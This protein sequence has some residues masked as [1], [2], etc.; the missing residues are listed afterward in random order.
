MGQ[1]KIPLVEECIYHICTKT[2]ADYVIF[3]AKKDYNR[4]L[5]TL[6]YYMHENIPCKFSAFL[7]LFENTKEEKL[8]EISDSNKLVEIIAYCIMPTH[9]HLLLKQVKKGGI[10]R[11]MEFVLKSYSKYF[12]AK[13]K[14]TGPLF[15]GRFKNILI[16]TNEQLLHVTRYIHLNP[17]SAY[18]VNKPEEWKFSSFNEYLDFDNKKQICNFTELIDL[19]PKNYREF[20]YDNIGYQRELQKIKHLTME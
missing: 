19:S 3:K 16:E 13:L 15:Q 7:E 8:A 20:V 18:L 10:S 4:I 17:V 1:R 12:N 6:F 5:G 2:I 11:Y 9:L 14:R